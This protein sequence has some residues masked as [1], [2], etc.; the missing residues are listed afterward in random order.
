M[1]FSLLTLEGGLGRPYPMLVFATANT[2]IAFFLNEPPR[3]LT[4]PVCFHPP[5]LVFQ[6]SLSKAVDI[7]SLGNTVN[8]RILMTMFLLT[9]FWAGTRFTNSQQAKS[10]SG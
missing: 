8:C 5:E 10:Y 9:V 2:S 3:T 4:T 7:W 1:T 6:H